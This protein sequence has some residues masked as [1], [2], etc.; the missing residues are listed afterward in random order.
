V[1][2]GSSIATERGFA[3]NVGSE[4]GIELT[5]QVSHALADEAAQPLRELQERAP[6]GF[7][8]FSEL[9]SSVSEWSFAYGIAWALLRLRDPLISSSA[10]DELARDATRRA[11]R[12]VSDESWTTLMAAD[13]ERRGPVDEERPP[14]LDEFMGK[15]ALTRTRRPAAR[16][17]ERAE[18]EE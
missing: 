11:W 12:L 15:V 10:V 17:P 4:S 5:R 2:C 18:P 13:R 8:Y 9:E 1:S 3:V 16:G 6:E 7:H 14:P